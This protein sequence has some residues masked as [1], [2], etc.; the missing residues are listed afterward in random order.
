MPFERLLFTACLLPGVTKFT[1]NKTSV[2]IQP[3]SKETVLFFCI[4]S[5]SKGNPG[6][7]GC[8]L[9]KEL[10]GE[11]QGERICDLLVFY[12]NA[13]SNR[14]ALCF[15]ELKDNRSDLG[16]A[17]K[18]VINTYKEI[19]KRLKLSNHYSILAF[20]I[21]HHG[22]A[23]TE[24]RRYQNDLVK[25]FSGNCIYDGRPD[26]FAA[27]LRGVSSGQKKSKGKK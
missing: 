15:V 16:D 11:K 21:C 7:S 22:A 6:C 10:W 5:N 4:D 3:T 13:D 25:A 24:H 2:V 14:R 27:L 18:Q 26:D 20:Q 8:N 23:P 12:A 17:T 19:K 9:R 1:E